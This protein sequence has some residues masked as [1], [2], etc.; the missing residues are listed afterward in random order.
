[1]FDHA[2]ACPNPAKTNDSDEIIQAEVQIREESCR[3]I[4]EIDRKLLRVNEELEKV[5]CS[6]DRTDYAVAIGSG[7]LSGIIDSVFSGEFS[8][9]KAHLWG[10]EKTEAF[11]IKIAKHIKNIENISKK[12]KNKQAKK[13]ND[14]NDAIKFLAEKASHND[15]EIK[16]GFHLASDSNMNDFGGANQHHLW[17]FAHHASIIGLFF[18]LLTQ[19]T[20]KCYGTDTSGK[21]IVVD[22]QKPE[23]IGKDVPQKLLFGTVYWFFHIVSDVAGSGNA[24]SEGTGIPGPILSLAKLLSSAKPFENHV[25]EKG[26]R[27]FSVFLSKLYNGTFFGKR[28]ENGKLIPLRFDFRTELGLSHE[29]SK[30][31]FPVLVNDVFVRTFYFLRHLITEIKEKDIST[32]DEIATINWEKT[33]PA[34]NRTIDRMLTISS[35]TF[36]LADTV[37]ASVHAAVESGGNWVLFAGKFVSRFN[38]IGAGR[39]AVAIVKEVSYQSKEAQLIHEKLL[40]TQ[41][42]TALVMEQLQEYK[43]ALEERVSTYLAEDIEAFLNGFSLMNEGMAFDDSDL[44][45]RGNVVIQ[46]VLG[47]K[48]Q[49]TT[50]EEFDNLMESDKPLQL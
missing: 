24:D 38:Y 1:M 37:D 7:I 4:E 47:R 43:S 46:K 12:D 49:F 5:V 23:F 8:L 26:N 48:P 50:Q 39:A 19:F 32:F 21:F 2:I 17:D 44:I 35:M 29:V 40:L 27:E 42:K 10:K 31:A 41:E 16:R 33:K 6:A 25:N 3:S 36:T 20:G 45:I 14:I 22:V 30:Q 11:V 9:E 28:D 18:S 13:I 34:G 15:K